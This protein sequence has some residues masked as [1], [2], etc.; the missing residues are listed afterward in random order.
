MKVYDVLGY[1]VTNYISKIREEGMVDNVLYWGELGYY[2]AKKHGHI[3][4]IAI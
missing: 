2:L 3:P 4:E 1:L